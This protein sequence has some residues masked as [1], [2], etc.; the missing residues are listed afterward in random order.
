MARIV[1]KF[2]GTS[3]SDVAHVRRAAERVRDAFEAGDEVAVVVSAMAGT[4]NRLDEWSREIGSMMDAREYDT[5]VAAGEQITAGLMALALQGLGI[6]SRS[7]LG[8]QLPLRTDDAHARARIL[9]IETGEIEARLSRREVP[10]LAGFQG[11]GPDERI[12]TLGRGGS[13]TSAVALATALRAERCD[14]YTDVDGVYTADPGL[15][16]G[17]RKVGRI[18]YEEMVELASLGARVLEPRAVAMAMRG[19]VDVQVRSSFSDTAGTLLVDEGAIMEQNVVTG[20]TYNRDEAKLTLVGIADVPGISARIF[21]PLS[22]KGVNVD[23]IVQSGSEQGKRINYTFTVVQADVERAVQT[24]EAAKESIGFERVVAEP[25]VAK[26]SIV[27][28]GMRTRPGVAQTMFATLA[29]ENINIQVIST[30][31]IKISVLI[32]ESRT[33]N[34]VR[35]LHAAYGLDSDKA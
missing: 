4:T 25:D 31:E 33:E 26:V 3:V 28:L 22:E 7:W 8:W 13:D 20:V 29:E 5:V 14:I 9:G 34:A 1:C 17:A 21:G 27:G 11:I 12:T 6:V 2:G 18:A 19:G 30:S 24:I 32:E 15:V 23:M 35:S 16:P 10:V